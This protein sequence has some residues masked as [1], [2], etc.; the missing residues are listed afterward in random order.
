MKRVV[1]IVLLVFLLLSATNVALATKYLTWEECSS[2]KGS[3]TIQVVAKTELYAHSRWAWSWSIRGK[4]GKFC[5]TGIGID[6]EQYN[7]MSEKEQDYVCNHKE[8]ALKLKRNKDG[9]WQTISVGAVGEP[10]VGEMILLMLLIVA[11]FGGL[12]Y[13]IGEDKVPKSEKRGELPKLLFILLSP[14]LVFGAVLKYLVNDEGRH[15]RRR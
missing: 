5:M 13:V 8:C 14:L 2:Y 7:S 1:T 11:I 3:G 12:V 15:R 9:T 6:E 4:S 10:S